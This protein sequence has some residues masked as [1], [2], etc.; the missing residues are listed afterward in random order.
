VT[1]QERSMLLD[2]EITLHA[3]HQREQQKLMAVLASR[4]G[5]SAV[6]LPNEI[7]SGPDRA[8]LIADIEGVIDSGVRVIVDDPADR[9]VVRT[10][11]LAEIRARRIELGSGPDSRTL[12]VAAPISIGRTMN[13]AQA[14]ASRDPR[15]V[16]DAHPEMTGIYGTFE[17]AQAQMI[18]L[19]QAGATTLRVTLADDFDIAD[20]LA[21]V[22]ALMVGPT[23]VLHEQ[24]SR[25]D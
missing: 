7:A 23:V 4:L 14:R 25:A 18:E 1:M 11:N 16:G 19:A 17:Q 10:T 5:Y 22:K 3:G 24:A 13:E 2:L 15:F 8:E 12:T 21:Q 9:S 20:L 6:V